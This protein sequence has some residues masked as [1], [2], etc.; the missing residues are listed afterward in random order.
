MRK[1]KNGWSEDSP[2]RNLLLAEDP[3]YGVLYEQEYWDAAEIDKHA[4]KIK[5]AARLS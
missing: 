4:D 1:G 3:A 2:F 5:T